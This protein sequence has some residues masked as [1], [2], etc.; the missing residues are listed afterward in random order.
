MFHVNVNAN[1]IV[2]YLTQITNGIMINV[3]VSEY[4]IVRAKTLYWESSYMYL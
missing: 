3:S 1:S 2:Q 4:S